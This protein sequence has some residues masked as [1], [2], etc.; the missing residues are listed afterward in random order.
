ME[1][2]LEMIKKTLQKYNQNHLISFYNELNRDEQ[3]RLLKQISS[4]DFDAMQ[5]LYETTKSN[6][7]KT[8]KKIEP[9]EYSTKDNLT[10]QEID[11]YLKIGID[12]LRNGKIA[13][14]HMAGGQRNKV[15]PFRTKRYFCNGHK[16]T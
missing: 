11:K 5:K 3:E 6:I 4:I 12:A 9:I 8:E 7:D 14:C 10:K 1:D 16:S 13:I 15:R 2:K